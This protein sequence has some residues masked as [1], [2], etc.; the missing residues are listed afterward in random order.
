MD[1]ISTAAVTGSKAGVAA[2]REVSQGFSG[3]HTMVSFMAV[4]YHS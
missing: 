4:I 3:V 1:W 2:S